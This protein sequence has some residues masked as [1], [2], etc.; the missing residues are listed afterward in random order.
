MTAKDIVDHARVAIE[1]FSKK[2]TALRRDSFRPVLFALC[3]DAYRLG[4]DDPQASQLTAEN[5]KA[6]LRR[7]WSAH[8]DEREW[9]YALER[10]QCLDEAC[11][12]WREWWYAFEHWKE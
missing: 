3:R 8:E 7:R 10:S 1:L 9:W 5:L 12:M 2:E 11:E 4:R 6:L